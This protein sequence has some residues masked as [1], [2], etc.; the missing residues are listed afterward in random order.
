MMIVL[1]ILLSVLVSLF[2]LLAYGTG[3]KIAM[4]WETITDTL[5]RGGALIVLAAI[6]GITYEALVGLWKWAVR[7]GGSNDN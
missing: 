6:A 5:Y 4:G 2:A 7:V 3:L 1:K